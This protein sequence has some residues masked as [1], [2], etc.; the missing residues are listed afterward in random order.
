MTTFDGDL[1][2][3]C[4]DENGL[5]KVKNETQILE[6]RYPQSSVLTVMSDRT[7]VRTEP[8][9]LESVTRLS[10]GQKCLTSAKNSRSLQEIKIAL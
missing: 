6:T 10:V 7:D 4:P 9:K 5:D 2:R 8:M 1:R 3:A